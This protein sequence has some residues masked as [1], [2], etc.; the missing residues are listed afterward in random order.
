MAGRHS[1]Y[2]TRRLFNTI[3]SSSS[4]TAEV[5]LSLDAEK[6]FDRL[7]WEYLFLI[8]NKF[9]FS[10][11]FIAWIQLLYTSPVAYVHTNTTHSK[12]FP[13]H[14]GTRQGCPLSHLLFLL[15]IEP[16]AISL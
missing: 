6:A 14:R 8:L 4:D 13:L 7:E 11:D 16:L 10:S 3:L 2:N 15:A 5:I 12:T 9:G 1:F